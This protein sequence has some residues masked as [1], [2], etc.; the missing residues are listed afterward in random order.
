MTSLI[1]SKKIQIS[2]SY[3][4]FLSS[5]H[6]Y[7]FQIS[8]QCAHACACSCCCAWL[9][10]SNDFKSRPQS[11]PRLHTADVDVFCFFFLF[12]FIL[13]ISSVEQITRDRCFTNGVAQSRLLSSDMPSVQGVCGSGSFNADRGDVDGR[14]HSSSSCLSSAELARKHNRGAR[15]PGC[16]S[17]SFVSPRCDVFRAGA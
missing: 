7:R 1:K 4:C 17:S 16:P 9:K 3:H 8:A 12:F 14:N 5:F 13:P 6:L 2:F 10:E 15:P 11:D